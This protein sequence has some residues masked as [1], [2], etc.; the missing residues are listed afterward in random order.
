M[1]SCPNTTGFVA[2]RKNSQFLLSGYRYLHREL[3]A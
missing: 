3:P 2:V 1:A